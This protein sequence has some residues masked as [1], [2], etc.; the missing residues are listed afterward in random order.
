MTEWASG[1][2]MRDLTLKKMICTIL[3]LVITI[4]VTC[5]CVKR[6]DI[7]PS[8]IITASPQQQEEN[9]VNRSIRVNGIGYLPDSPKT[10]LVDD[11]MQS[12]MK[13]CLVD[14]HSGD[15][16]YKGDLVK[17]TGDLGT[18]YSG[19]FSSFEDTGEYFITVGDHRSFDFP[20]KPT[21]NDDVLDAR[22]EYFSLQRCGDT[23][24]GYMG[25]PCHMDDHLPQN[26]YY[27]TTGGWHDAC[28]LRKWNYPTITGLVGL[29]A[30]L[31]TDTDPERK[32][33]IVSEIKWG[34]D[35][36]I[37]MIRSD[38]AF[39]NWDEGFVQGKGNTS[40]KWTDNILGNDDDRVSYKQQNGYALTEV[41]YLYSMAKAAR[42][43]KTIDPVYAEKM[44]R[45]SEKTAKL[46]Y[47][48][49]S[50]IYRRNTEIAG[51]ACAASV[52]MFKLTGDTGWKEKAVKLASE[53]LD[54]Q[55]KTSLGGTD[56][57][58]YFGADGNEIKSPKVSCA[59]NWALIGL[60]ETWTNFRDHPDSKLWKDSISSFCNDYARKVTGMNTFGIM[61][62]AITTESVLGDGK[63]RRFGESLLY[64]R[65]FHEV[66]GT[67]TGW[68]HYLGNTNN[69]MSNAV[70]LLM[71]SLVLDDPAVR[72]MAQNQYDWVSGMN[73][74]GKTAM[75]F[76]D[77]SG[78][79]KDYSTEYSGI[80][81]YDDFPHFLAAELI[82]RKGVD[83]MQTPLLNGGVRNGIC[84]SAD[85][86]PIEPTDGWQSS[87]YWTPS[88]AYCMW[89]EIYSSNYSRL[90][91][92]L[93]D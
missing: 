7:T 92:V 38:G 47:E 18:R 46:V 79:Y 93:T 31:E 69:L 3:V 44:I 50:T 80:N 91:S 68:P 12:N 32:N 85:D 6:S 39:Y 14:K 40:N 63:N 35:Y 24:L 54:N 33:A 10:V 58:G 72:K 28:D 13:F 75:T 57:K 37:K 15:V 74:A 55:V 4:S 82:P 87:E 67:S 11:G 51:A 23:V 78:K 25:Q 8:S 36:F 22:V 56:I 43:M 53:L 90:D 5:G 73:T 62:Y 2:D 66:T 59:G 64:Y 29:S 19:D 61:P 34:A 77:S 41:M 17:L 81:K 86:D 48:D 26:Q 84:G 89:Y 16:V 45:G 20:I 30:M 71:A 88:I 70:G 83:G 42:I 60:C 27:D 52:Q 9:T 21:L 1:E 49:I 65:Y 76:V